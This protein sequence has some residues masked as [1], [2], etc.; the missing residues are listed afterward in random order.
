MYRAGRQTINVLI[1]LQ[2]R[3]E[4]RGW[5]AAKFQNEFVC[6]WRELGGGRT[7]KKWTK[8]ILAEKNFLKKRSF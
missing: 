1:G 5:G 3:S 8:Y 6:R 7:W 4:T 2:A